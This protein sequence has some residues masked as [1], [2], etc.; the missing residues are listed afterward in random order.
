MSSDGLGENLEA[1]EDRR[2]PQPLVQAHEVPTAGYLP[3]PQQGGGELKVE[4]EV[5]RER[6]EAFESGVVVAGGNSTAR[7]SSRVARRECA[8]APRSSA[9]ARLGQLR[10]RL[11]T[12]A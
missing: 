5:G 7:S 2:H 3:R 12:T 8:L 9:A 4:L 10:C 1:L 6:K 11:R